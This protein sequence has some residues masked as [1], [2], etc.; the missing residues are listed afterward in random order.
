MAGLRERYVAS[1]LPVS[2]ISDLTTEEAAPQRGVS[3]RPHRRG[4]IISRLGAVFLH[5]GMVVI[6]W[7]P[8]RVS[9][10]PVREVAVSVQV[11][12]A[13]ANPL[14]P[15]LPTP[16]GLPSPSPIPAVPPAPALP[17][18][19]S[20]QP[21][22]P[23]PPP[24]APSPSVRRLDQPAQ[25][26]PAFH[27]IPTAHAA[28]T[29]QT[30]STTPASMA[31]IPA[32]STQQATTIPSQ[33]AAQAANAWQAQLG[34]WLQAHKHYPEAARDMDEEGNVEIRFTVAQDG[35]VTA[36]SVVQGS[37]APILDDAALAMLQDATVPAL[38]PT[39]AQS[40]ITITVE[41]RYALDE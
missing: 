11:M 24:A 17:P 28:P 37:G 8:T 19:V 33:S 22:L 7:L 3:S 39:M 20:A 1:R 32:A 34:A 5:V 21:A 15:A 18:G 2:V 40:A 14:S 41:L 13:P 30:A 10:Q 26:I 25:K 27:A 38:P 16:A 35:R 29:T 23:L 31:D 6:L 36:V 4:V 12:P 9:S